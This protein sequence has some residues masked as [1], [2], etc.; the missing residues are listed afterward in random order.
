MC[1]SINPFTLSCPLFLMHLLHYQ[2]IPCF[3]SALADRT[4]ASVSSLQVGFYTHNTSRNTI[5]L[6]VIEIEDIETQ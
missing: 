1:C 2:F 3:V 6:A 5:G 4:E